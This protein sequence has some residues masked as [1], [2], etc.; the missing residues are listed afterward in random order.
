MGE[1]Q[2]EHEPKVLLV[3]SRLQQALMALKTRMSCHF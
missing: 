2:V 1:L 3:R